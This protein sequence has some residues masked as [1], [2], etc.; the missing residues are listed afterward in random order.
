[1]YRDTHKDESLLSTKIYL[2]KSNNLM[3]VLWLLP[4]TKSGYDIFGKERNQ[5]TAVGN[6]LL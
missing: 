3:A 6:H 2:F 4:Q 5:F 1:M